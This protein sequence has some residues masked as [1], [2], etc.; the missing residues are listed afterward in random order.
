MHAWV[1]R[2]GV[3]HFQPILLFKRFHNALEI[4]PPFASPTSTEKR[5]R[6][7]H[8]QHVNHNMLLSVA[9]DLL[10][11]LMVLGYNGMA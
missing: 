10:L 8:S 6:R 11:Q 2:V 3:K 7:A 4:W 1:A 5:E 9:W